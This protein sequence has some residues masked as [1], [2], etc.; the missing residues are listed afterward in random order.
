MLATA[1]AQ[2][3]L[4]NRE[5]VVP[6]RPPLVTFPLALEG[7]QG[8]PIPIED[9]AV[10]RGLG[11]SDYLLADFTDGADPP[12]N[13]W[14][15]YYDEQLGNA[16]IHS[17]KDCLPGAGWEYASLGGVRAPVSGADG[18]PFTI[19]RGLIVNGTDQMLIYY[20][21]DIRGRKVTSDFALK[22]YNLWDS[23]ALGRS[24][25]ALI[26]VM[27]IVAP[28]ELVEAADERARAFIASAYPRLEPF[29][30]Q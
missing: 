28:G 15:A 19:N 11:A 17:P 27:T 4:T 25:G 12:V 5:Q 29:V 18:R 24:D 26:R 23:Y 16:A 3:P 8:R 10:L 20:W 1:L 21:L 6:E 14:I 13:L 7:W 22:L 9:P 30:G 2:G